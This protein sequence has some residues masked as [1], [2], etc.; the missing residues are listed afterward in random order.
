MSNKAQQF[1]KTEII[2]Q[3]RM[4]LET[5]LQS[6]TQAAK[7]AHE[8]ATHEE[9]KAEDQHDTRGLESSYLAGAAEQRAADIQKQIHHYKFLEPKNF[10]PE[11]AVGPTAVVE[12]ESD[13]KRSLYFVAVLGGGMRVQVGSQSIQVITPHSPLGEEIVGRKAGDVLEIEAQGVV[14]EYEILSI[15]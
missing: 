2:A 9:S 10:K 3:I 15:C 11:D 7:A 13:G 6:V 4:K 12:V 14:R 1:D 5:E 8:A